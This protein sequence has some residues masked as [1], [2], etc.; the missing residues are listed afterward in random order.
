MVKSFAVWPREF[1]LSNVTPYC[2]K[3]LNISG[4]APAAA[5]MTL[6]FPEL[7]TS[8]QYNPALRR[9]SVTSRWFLKHAQCKGLALSYLVDPMG[10]CLYYCL[11]YKYCWPAPLAKRSFTIAVCP[12]QHAHIR[13][14]HFFF[15]FS[16]LK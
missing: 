13:A 2:K 11:T 9:I 6:L 10:T 15:V 12:E 7:S 16:T 14:F 5:N 1:L 8:Y 4:A 3:A